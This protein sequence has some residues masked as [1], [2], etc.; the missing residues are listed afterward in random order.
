MNT[1]FQPPPQSSRPAVINY[2]II[3]NI[4]GSVMAETTNELMYTFNGVKGG[5]YLFS[6]V[7]VNTLGSGEKAH[8]NATGRHKIL[9]DITINKKVP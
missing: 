2:Q 4:T 6:I 9:V 8:I 5:V 1:F 3:H 7:A